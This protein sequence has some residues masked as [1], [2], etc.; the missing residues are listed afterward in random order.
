MGY[1]KQ[2]N[3]LLELPLPVIQGTHLSCLEPARDTM[4]VE[5]MLKPTQPWK[6]TQDMTNVMQNKMSIKTRHESTYTARC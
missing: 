2:S 1:E 5:C 4:E 3:L 6:S